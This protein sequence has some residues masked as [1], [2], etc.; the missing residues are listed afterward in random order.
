MK[1]IIA[2]LLLLFFLAAC[3][4][5][6]PG[7]NP[8]STAAAVTPTSAS[9]VEQTPTSTVVPPP[10]PTVTFTPAAPPTYETEFLAYEQ[11]GQLLVTNVTGGEQGGTTQYTVSGESDEVTDLAWSPSGEFAAFTSTA[12][13]EPHIFYFFALGQSS[14]TDLGPGS[15]PVWSPDSRSIAYIRGG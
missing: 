4:P 7:L 11:G 10:L 6:Q 13:G 14:P 15:Q 12:K 5:A 8:T 3:S 9:P 2:L 1:K